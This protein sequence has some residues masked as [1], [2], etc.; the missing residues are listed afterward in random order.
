MWIYHKNEYDDFRHITSVQ[1]NSEQNCQFFIYLFI[2]CLPTK[3]DTEIVYC[4]TSVGSGV[5][6]NRGK[7]WKDETKLSLFNLRDSVIH[8][9][10]ILFLDDG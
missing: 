9:Y 5:L 1:K 8:V 3:V 7:V 2:H 4:D 10:C 6:Q